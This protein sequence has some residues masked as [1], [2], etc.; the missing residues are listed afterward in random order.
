MDA[1]VDRGGDRGASHSR[2]RDA[3]TR[4]MTLTEAEQEVYDRQIRVW[5]LETQRTIGAS[6]ILVSFTCTE[7]DDDDDDDRGEKNASSTRSSCGV[8]A[9]T[10]KNVT[11][12][13]VGALTIRNDDRDD[14][15]SAYARTVG[16]DGNFLNVER[17]DEYR[18]MGREPKDVT[19]ASNMAQTLSEMNAFGKITAEDGGARGKKLYEE[20]AD[21]FSKFDVVVACGY[22]FAEAEAI[23]D[24]CR[25][26]NC[27]FFGAF[28]GASARYFFADLG[29]AFEY[30]AGSGE[31]VAAGV[32]RYS[33][34]SEALGARAGANDWTKLKKRASKIPLALR[35]VREFERRHSNRRATA[36][37]WDAL[38]ALR[39]ELAGAFGAS[40]EDIVDEASIRALLRPENDFPAMNA[41]VGG[42]LG[43]EVLKRA[44]RRGAPSVNAFFFDLASGQGFVH[45]FTP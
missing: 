15:A 16:R 8:A 22:T 35:V 38:D 27:G 13:G 9:E 26:S 2:A 10:A 7:E 21:Y 6:R 42:I 34:M 19:L 28:T 12:A 32:A 40:S 45:D 20:D 23:N 4:A 29:D 5:G 18:A 37:D 44:S 17:A 3:R 31:S 1:S 41:V 33:R 43:Q 30:V 36:N 39:R 11:L 14:D 25:T 24:L